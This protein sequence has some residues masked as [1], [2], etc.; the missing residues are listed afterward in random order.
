MKTVLHYG[1]SKFS[2]VKFIIDCA[3]DSKADEE[4]IFEIP[5]ITDFNGYSP[6]CLTFKDGNPDMRTAD[7]MLDKYLKHMPLDH[8]GKA[9][10]EVIPLCIKNQVNSLPDYFEARLLSS[11]HIDKL[12]RSLKLPEDGDSDV[13]E[14]ACTLWPAKQTVIDNLD[15]VTF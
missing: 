10:A 4:K 15:K 3:K 7:Y 2:M 1:A 12:A 8:H 14:S 9:V 6:L 5:F 13:Y 11:K